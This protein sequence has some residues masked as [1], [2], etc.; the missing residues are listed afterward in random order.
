MDST[1][2]LWAGLAFILVSSFA[3]LLWAGDAI[4]RAAPPLPRQVV[5]E[6]GEVLYTKDDINRGRQVWQ[7]IGGMQLG[8]IWGHG[9]YVAPDWSADWLHREAMAVLDLW[10]VRQGVERYKVLTP[11]Q[12]GLLRAELEPMMRRNTYD[13]TTGTITLTADRIAAIRQVAQHYVNLFGTDRTTA[14]LR[15]A[16]AMKNDTVPDPSHRQALTAFFWWTAWG[17]ATERPGTTGETL[18]PSGPL[19]EQRV[20]YT[21]NWPSEPL[22]GNRPPPALWLWSAFSVVFLL[23]GIGL[24]GWY[25]ARTHG[26]DRPEHLPAVD[27]LASLRI[28]PSMRATAKYFWVVLALFLVQI[29]LGAITAHYQVEGQEAYGYTLSDALPYSITRTWHTQLAVLWIAVAWLGT[30]LYIAP[31]L[32]GHEPKFQRLGVNFLFACLLIIVIGSFAGQWLAIMQK[33]GLELNFWW[34]HQG[35]EY[36]DMG[37]FWQCFLFGGLLLWLTLVGRALWPVLRGQSTEMKAVV[38][39]LFLSTVCIGLFFGAALMWGEHTHL[40]EVE[41]WR[42]WLVHLWVEGFFEVFAA[43]VMALIFTRL[44]LV[45]PDSAT[46]AVLFATIVFMAGGVLGTLHHLYFV[47]TPTSVVALGASFSALEV[48]P[49]AYI[50]FEAYNTY[51]MGRATSW[52]VHYKWPILFFIAVSFWN[53]VGAGLFGFLINPPLSLYFMQG[54]NL[55]P[56]HGHTALFGVYG[57]LG[58]ALVLFCVRGLRAQMLWDTKMLKLSFWALN[59]GLAMMAAFTLLPLGVLQLLAA[60]EHGYWYARS[61]EFMQKPIVELLVWLRVPGDLIFSVGA[62]ALAWFIF[63]LWVTPRFASESNSTAPVHKNP[64]R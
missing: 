45:R 22:I 52:M 56:L 63:R 10:A 9:G 37:R 32:S 51:R 40:S 34:G 6:S 44:G 27:P 31:A 43:A 57:M 2:K 53:L 8:S 17:A 33:L 38:G 47:G 36:A 28:T 42:W 60:I 11:S 55:T 59:I 61:A 21:N 24:L 29:L 23:A 7:S 5:S 15:E 20:T 35:W 54:L 39:L 14:E 12:Q 46:T 58:I 3:A 64:E 13:P 25:H 49:L 4:F 18:A 48:V 62:L 16:Y 30:G 41:Y 1:R 19:P 26:D 50:G